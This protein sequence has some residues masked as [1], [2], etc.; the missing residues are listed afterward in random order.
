MLNMLKL[1]LSY[2]FEFEAYIYMLYRAARVGLQVTEIIIM[3]AQRMRVS[4]LTVTHTNN[5]IDILLAIELDGT[6][7]ID[8]KLD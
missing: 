7:T 6:I 2:D 8:L 3:H 1:K 4:Y 5:D